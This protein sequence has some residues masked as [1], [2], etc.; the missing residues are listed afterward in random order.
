MRLE[1]VDPTKIDGRK[2]STEERGLGNR[3]MF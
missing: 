3:L 1:I 2:V